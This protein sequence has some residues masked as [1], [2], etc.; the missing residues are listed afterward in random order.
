M[1]LMD[2]D[3]KHIEHL[4]ARIREL[5]SIVQQS[6]TQSSKKSIDVNSD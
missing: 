4:E 3:R 6:K 5:Q 2:K 1:S